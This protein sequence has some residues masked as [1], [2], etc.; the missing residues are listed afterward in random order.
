MRYC[1]AD[2]HRRLRTAQARAKFCRRLWLFRQTLL[3][4]EADPWP[5]ELAPQTLGTVDCRTTIPQ[6]ESCCSAHPCI[7][8]TTSNIKHNVD[9]DRPRK[10]KG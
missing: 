2:K 9:R 6:K 1:L 4:E 3:I 10:P 7:T 5:Q 8:A